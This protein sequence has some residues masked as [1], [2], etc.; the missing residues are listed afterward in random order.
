MYEL[1]EFEKYNN[2]QSDQKRVVDLFQDWLFIVHMLFLLQSNDI[3]NAHYFQCKVTFG[4]FFLHQ[5]NTPKGARAW[6]VKEETSTYCKNEKKKKAKMI[7]KIYK[8]NK[9]KSYRN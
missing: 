8:I 4:H 2:L 6:K 7:K 9:I 5:M 1:D 3:R